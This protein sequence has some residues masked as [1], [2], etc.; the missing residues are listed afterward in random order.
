MTE[1]DAQFAERLRSLDRDV[2]VETNQLVTAVGE[3]QNWRKRR[4]AQVVASGLA[5]ALLFLWIGSWPTTEAPELQ[6]D[7]V[8]ANPVQPKTLPVK[9][10]AITPVSLTEQI[11]QDLELKRAK[12]EWAVAEAKLARLKKLK[13]EMRHAALRETLSRTTPSIYLQK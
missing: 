8:A 6:T 5:V 11:I 3:K 7:H 12:Q 4:R 9:E 13:S 2:Q 1:S 10:S